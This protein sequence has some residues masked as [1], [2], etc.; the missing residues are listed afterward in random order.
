[1][2]SEPISL[3]IR[4]ASLHHPSRSPD[5]ITAHL[6]PLIYQHPPM[7]FRQA[8]GVPGRC[9]VQPRSRISPPHPG[10]PAPPAGN[11]RP[12][13]R[14]RPAD[15]GAGERGAGRGALRVPGTAEGFGLRVAGSGDSG[16]DRSLSPYTHLTPCPPASRGILHLT[17]LLDQPFHER[18]DRL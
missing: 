4:A 8:S 1:M 13:A 18:E 5:C 11:R 16:L 10:G 6:S 7:C 3:A 2:C 14:R 15:G 9:R 12:C 17:L